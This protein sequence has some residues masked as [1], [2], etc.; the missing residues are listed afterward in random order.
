MS[1]AALLPFRLV[2][3]PAVGRLR[4]LPPRRFVRGV[5]V[6][7]AGQPLARIEISGTDVLVL[8][9]VSGRVTAVLG[10][11]G[12]PIRSGDAVMSIEPDGR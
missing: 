5:E 7:E 10:L 11:D 2:V 1:E 12:Q 6:V 8:A 4:L 9:P 3:A